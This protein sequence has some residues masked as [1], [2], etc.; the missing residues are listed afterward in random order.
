MLVIAKECQIGKNRKNYAKQNKIFKE[1]MK[2][3][4][5]CSSRKYF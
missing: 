2:F 5:I 4:K 1:K 3:N